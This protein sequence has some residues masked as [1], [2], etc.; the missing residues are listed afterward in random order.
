[1][2][3]RPHQCS[4]AIPF[5]TNYQ[6]GIFFYQF[7]NVKLKFFFRRV[8]LFSLLLLS[9]LLL[10]SS[11]VYFVTLMATLVATLRF[12]PFLL[13]REKGRDHK[14]REELEIPGT[15]LEIKQQVASLK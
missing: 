14:N 6:A 1:V 5:V 3:P 10:S 4:Q 12:W 7:K 2:I 9:C 8:H 11:V 15:A 13:G